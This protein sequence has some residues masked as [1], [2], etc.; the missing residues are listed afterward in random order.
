MPETPAS[1]ARRLP[2]RWLIGIASVWAAT[3]DAILVRN[4][5]RPWPAAIVAGVFMGGFVA[6]VLRWWRRSLRRYRQAR[7]DANTGRPTEGGWAN[8]RIGQRASARWRRIVT[9]PGS[10]I[11]ANPLAGDGVP[12]WKR[13]R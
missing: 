5:G 9:R 8:P 11:K 3:A 1:S 10:H 12:F 7:A 6:V 4:G 2:E 13:R